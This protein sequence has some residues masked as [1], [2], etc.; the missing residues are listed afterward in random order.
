MD[1]NRL[2][3]TRKLCKLILFPVLLLA[4]GCSFAPTRQAP[5]AEK[6][7]VYRPPTLAPAAQQVSAEDEGQAGAEQPSG[8]TGEQASGASPADCTDQLV[9]ISDVTIPDG[10][11]VV[12]GATLD[13]RWEVEN[14]GT[15]NWDASYTLQKVEGPELNVT[16]AQTMFPARAG[17]RPIIRIVFTAPT[18]P[19]TYRSAW[20]AFN[21]QGQAFG[22]IF[23]I[24]IIVGSEQP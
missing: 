19:G 18:E 8:E 15:C 21:P 9:F 20:Q 17:S 22:D 6:E 2:M 11:V 7:P 5:S 23:Y 12:P 1:W 13:K 14:A 10:T 4:A 3:N 24:E 16:S